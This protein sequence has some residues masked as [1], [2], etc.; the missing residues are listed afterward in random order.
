[1]LT[2]A[3]R[4]THPK[5]ILISGPIPCS[6]HPDPIE[7]WPLEEDA[8]ELAPKILAQFEHKLLRTERE[9]LENLRRRSLYDTSNDTFTSTVRHLCLEFG[10]QVK[11]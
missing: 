11:D 2:P 3:M 10:W 4:R 7:S 1:M 5:P 8:V 6:G 9:A